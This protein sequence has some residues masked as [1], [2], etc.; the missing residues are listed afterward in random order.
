[1]KRLSI[2]S[3]T[4]RTDREERIV[5]VYIS[6]GITITERAGSSVVGTFAWAMAAHWWSTF[7]YRQAMDLAVAEFKEKFT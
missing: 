6:D 5:T 4:D 7:R 2:L 1:M 3:C